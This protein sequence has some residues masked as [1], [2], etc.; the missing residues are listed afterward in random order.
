MTEVNEGELRKLCWCV[1]RWR[2]S[3]PADSRKKVENKLLIKAFDHLRMA[4]AFRKLM[5]YWLNFSNNRV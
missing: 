1:T 5:R 4:V 2:F 3:S